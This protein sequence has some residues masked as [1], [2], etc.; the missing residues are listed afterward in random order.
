[1]LMLTV[2]V[3]LP[4]RDERLTEHLRSGALL[5]IV[6]GVLAVPAGF[7]A[8]AAAGTSYA[9]IYAVACSRRDRPRCCCRRCRRPAPAAPTPWR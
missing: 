9:A 3:H 7:A 4:L 5:A 1:M 6:V 2:G 8:A